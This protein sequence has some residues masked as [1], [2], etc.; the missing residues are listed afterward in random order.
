MVEDILT[1]TPPPLPFDADDKIFGLYDEDGQPIGEMHSYNDWM[2]MII[3]MS[4][5]NPELTNEK[6]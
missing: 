6:A 1:I 2:K 5:V 3:D 4:G